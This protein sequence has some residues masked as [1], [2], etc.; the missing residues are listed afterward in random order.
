MLGSCLHK[1]AFFRNT[2]YDFKEDTIYVYIPLV[3]TNIFNS[4]GKFFRYVTQKSD[5]YL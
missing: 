5:S 1:K 4:K 3:L 2:K